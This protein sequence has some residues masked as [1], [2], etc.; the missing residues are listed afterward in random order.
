[1]ARRGPLQKAAIKGYLEGIKQVPYVKRVAVEYPDPCLVRVWTLI[2]APPFD[3]SYSGSIHELELTALE[4]APA[5]VRL[6]FWLLNADELNEAPE[7]VVPESAECAY[8]RSTKLVNAE[9]RSTP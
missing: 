4:A 2:A 5:E 9:P 7:S 6:D 1:M 8:E 3:F